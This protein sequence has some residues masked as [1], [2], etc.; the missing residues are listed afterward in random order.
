MSY[1]VIFNVIVQEV[2]KLRVIV[3]GLLKNYAITSING[4]TAQEVLIINAIAQEV[5]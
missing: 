4:V 3:Q 2:L 5:Q 1:K